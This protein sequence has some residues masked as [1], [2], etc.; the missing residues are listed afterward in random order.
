MSMFYWQ[1]GFRFR[2]AEPHQHRQECLCHTGSRQYPRVFY[3]KSPVRREG[4]AKCRINVAQTLLS[5]LVR[6]GTTDQS[7]RIIA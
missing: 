4:T 3:T 6:L 1:W 7:L 2:S 5:V